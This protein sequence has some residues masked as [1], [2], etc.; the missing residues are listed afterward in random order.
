VD[1]ADSQAG[2]QLATQSGHSA[3]RPFST[4]CGHWDRD[5]SRSHMVPQW[6]VIAIAIGS[7]LAGVVVQTIVR[8]EV[9]RKGGNIVWEWALGCLSFILTVGGIWT[10]YFIIGNLVT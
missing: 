6:V 8:V 10:L 1:H 7:T 5:Y 9:F 2:C 4:H 3:E